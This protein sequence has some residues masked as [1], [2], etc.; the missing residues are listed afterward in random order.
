MLAILDNVL[1][2]PEIDLFVNISVDVSVTTPPSVVIVISLPLNDVVIP[3]PPKIVKPPPS[4]TLTV[5]ELSSEIVTVEFVSDELGTFVNAGPI[6]PRVALPSVP[7]S[8]TI[9]WS[10]ET[11]VWPVKFVAV[12]IL[13]IASTAPNSKAFPSLLTLITWPAV[14]IDNATPVP[15]W[16]KPTV[17]PVWNS[18]N[19]VATLSELKTV[20]IGFLSAIIL[21]LYLFIKIEIV[22]Y[23]YQLN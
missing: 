5:V 3:D 2:D 23:Y 9:N 22:W 10:A 12:S 18:A 11:N 15:P 19:P 1:V 6:W 13:I 21:S 17:S 16:S 7:L 4:G 14:P 20:R 8:D